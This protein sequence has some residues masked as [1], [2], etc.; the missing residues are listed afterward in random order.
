METGQSTG[1]VSPLTHSNVSNV[2]FAQNHKL[3]CFSVALVRN[4]FHGCVEPMPHTGKVNQMYFGWVWSGRGIIPA[5]S[6][7]MASVQSWYPNVK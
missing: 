3:Y 6:V 2:L 5:K 7:G 4:T 1:A